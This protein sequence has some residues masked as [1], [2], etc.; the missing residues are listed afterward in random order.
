MG[1]V[2]V[3]PD[4]FYA[5]S[6]HPRADEAVDHGLAL[7]EQGASILDVGGESTRPGARPVPL[8]EE[9]DRVIPVIER[10]RARTSVLLS[11]DTRKAAVA[12]RALQ[13]GADVINDVSALRFDPEMAAVLAGS[14]AGLV[15]MHMLGTPETMQREPLDVDAV[16]GVRAFLAEAVARAESFG[17]APTAILVD[18]G[19]GFGKTL[20]GNLALLNGIDALAELGKPV[21]VG[22]SRKSFLGRLTGKPAENRIFGTA[23]SVA[24]AV[25]RGASV[26]RAHD[27]REMRDV[28]RVAEAV[29]AAGVPR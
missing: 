29:R 9:L 1:V 18:P 8:D 19:I 25:L 6:R 7:A 28:V 14:G 10:L 21:L 2:N 12:R 4:S 22:P 15:L 27:V 16:A 3:T 23:A 20:A 13:A 26:V 5:A 11:V 17:V 24:C